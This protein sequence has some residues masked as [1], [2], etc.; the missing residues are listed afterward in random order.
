MTDW[1]IQ[2]RATFC[3]DCRTPFA[4]R[5]PYHTLLSVTAE[6]YRRRD[7]C[8]RCYATASRDGVF[9][10]WQ[11]EYRVPPP[12]PS[13]PIEKNTAENILRKLIQSHDPAHAG[14]RYILAVMLERKRI[15]K[16]RDT[17]HEAD[18]RTLLV[19]EHTGTGE[20]FTIPDPKL[21]LDQ[22]DEVRR[23][24]ADLLE[25]RPTSPTFS[26]EHASPTPEQ[27]RC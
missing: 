8:Q 6:G 27:N 19:Y 7:L 15:L 10:Y 23:E 1:D 21:R 16:H 17:V 4:D 13:E 25:Q 22:L 18:G 3:A 2:P 24:V 12:R 26:G 5:H 9:S 20:S 14:A 11:G